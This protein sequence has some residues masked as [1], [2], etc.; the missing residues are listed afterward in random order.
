M[1]VLAATQDHLSQVSYGAVNSRETSVSPALSRHS[2]ILQK[3]L[4]VDSADTLEHMLS[5]SADKAAEILGIS[6]S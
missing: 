1:Y 4:G 2:D 5:S 3:L 6:C